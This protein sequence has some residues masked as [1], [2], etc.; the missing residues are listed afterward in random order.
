MVE[1]ADVVDI[2]EE[3]KAWLEV[4]ERHY[5]PHGLTEQESRGTVICSLEFC[6]E[7]DSEA[8]CVIY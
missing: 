4:G 3:V 1:G 8:P 5:W 6:V 7:K 2:T